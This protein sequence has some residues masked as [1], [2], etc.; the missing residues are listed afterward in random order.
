MD[1]YSAAIQ[2]FGN[3]E[4]YDEVLRFGFELWEVDSTNVSGKLMEL[5]NNIDSSAAKG[6]YDYFFSLHKK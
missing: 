6:H 5:A 2:L 3:H 1:N 4:M